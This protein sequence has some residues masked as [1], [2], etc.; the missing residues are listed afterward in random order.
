MRE[1]VNKIYEYR[2][3][4]LHEGI[5]FPAPMCHSPWTAGD[6]VFAEKFHAFAMGTQGGVW[7]AEDIPML[8]HTFEYIVRK[9]LLRWWQSMAAGNV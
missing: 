9:V 3:K 5:P 8:L 7:Q 1:S 4:A 2:S 6:G